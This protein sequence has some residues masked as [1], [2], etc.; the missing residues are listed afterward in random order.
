M[1]Y[2]RILSVFLCIGGVLEDEKDKMYFIR[3]YDV[4]Y[5]YSL[6]IRMQDT[7]ACIPYVFFAYFRCIM[8][9]IGGTIIQQEYVQNTQ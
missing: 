4:F 9:R 7:R 1:Y 5:P 6:C 2:A 3:I 8:R